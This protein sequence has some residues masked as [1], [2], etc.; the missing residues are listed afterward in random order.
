MNSP[1]FN[2]ISKAG[3]ASLGELSA[4][5]S[6]APY[7][8]AVEIAKMLRNGDVTLSK[9]AD[10]PGI[11]SAAFEEV[12]HQSPAFT[13]VIGLINTPRRLVELAEADTELF[14]EGIEFAL[15]DDRSSGV[16]NVNPTPKGFRSS[17]A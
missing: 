10:V 12:A 3:N 11:E 4:R 5:S 6:F 2:L 9:S 7:A 14:V 13:K 1:L 16:I 8:L 17:V 15:K